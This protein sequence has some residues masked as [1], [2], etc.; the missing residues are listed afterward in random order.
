MTLEFFWF[1][2]LAT[3]LSDIVLISFAA[4]ATNVFINDQ[5]W[6][7][8]ILCPSNLQNG[9]QDAQGISEEQYQI[10]CSRHVSLMS[11][12]S[13]CMDHSLIISV[14]SAE[15]TKA[16]CIKRHEQNH[17]Q[18]SNPLCERHKRSRNNQNF[19]KH[20]SEQRGHSR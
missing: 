17:I 16:A 12:V 1:I 8:C 4:P 3:S 15:D 2:T 5:T 19:Y 11:D 20:V 9:K 18:D 10:F 14:R 13:Q 7:N 6:L